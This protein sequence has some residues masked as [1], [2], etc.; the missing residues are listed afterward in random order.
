LRILLDTHAIL[1]LF[2]TPEKLSRKAQK[3]YMNAEE[4]FVSPAS[5]WEIGNKVAIGKLQLKE[6][7]PKKIQSCLVQEGIKSTPI[8]IEDCE[9][10]SKL[11][12]HHRDPFDRMLIAQATRRNLT[13]LSIDEAMKEYPVKVLW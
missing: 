4:V 5:F 9:E 11:P 6:D 13:L 7:W 8:L 1:W 10:L 3:A 12:L 2:S